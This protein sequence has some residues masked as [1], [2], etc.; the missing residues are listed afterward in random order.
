MKQKKIVLVFTGRIGSGKDTATA[1]FKERYGAVGFKFSTSMRDIVNRVYMEQSREHL[2]W[3]GAAFREHFGEDV[4]AHTVAEDIKS[5][6]ATLVI[7]EGA[8]FINDIK[9]VKA[10]PGFALVAIDVPQETRYQR[11]IGR[12][13]NSD[14]ASKTWDDFV[15][16]DVATTEIEIEKLMKLASVTIDNNGAKEE[17][18]AQ[19]EDLYKNLTHER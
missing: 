3:V 6:E 10:L 5:T 4:F 11:I 15:R 14:D 17:L 7:V 8:R 1:F 18:F 2:Q 13:E 12:R 19:L 16:E 9:F